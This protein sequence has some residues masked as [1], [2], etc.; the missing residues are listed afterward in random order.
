MEVVREGRWWSPRRSTS[1]PKLDAMVDIYVG[2]SDV[3]FMVVA[4]LR[5]MAFSLRKL[6]QF[7]RELAVRPSKNP[8]EGE[9]YDHGVLCMVVLS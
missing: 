6:Y 9:N 8:F 5:S 4:R 3:L 7:L 1:S 2:D